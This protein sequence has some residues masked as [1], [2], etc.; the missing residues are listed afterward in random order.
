MRGVY[1]DRIEA[2]VDIWSAILKGRIKS[3][4]RAV[5]TLREV[6]KRRNVEP[7][8]GRT[9][10]DIFDKEMATL[11]LV[12]RYGLGL[13]DEYG[14]LYEKIFGRELR[15]ERALER[16]LGGEDPR[17]VIG[18]ELGEI[19]EN[20]VFRVIRLTFTAALLGFRSEDSLVELLSRLEEAFPE[21]R[22][23]FL[24]FKKFYIAFKIA[25]GIAAGEVRNRLE[26]EALK[27]A[28][29]IKFNA[30]K[31]AP[32]DSLIR[33]IAV[34]VLKVDEFRVN[35]ALKVDNIELKI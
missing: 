3:R 4:E 26:K 23:R 18:E 12:G 33:E 24:G 15:C 28:L 29:C 10:I 14:E 16:I 1:R 2:C 5:E 13:G 27:H 7:L 34:G 6:Y 20:L 11:Y 25:E 31:S 32:P 9:K 8:R 19:N 17:S 21:Y 30:R 35:D 22:K